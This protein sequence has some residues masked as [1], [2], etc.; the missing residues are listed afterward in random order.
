MGDMTMSYPIASN[1]EARLAALYELE[2]L[3][4]PDEPAFDRVTRLVTQLLNVPISTIT[5]IDAERQWIKSRVGVETRE[6][7][8]DV[9]FCAYTVTASE[10]LIVEDARRILDLRKTPM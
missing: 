10:P 2:L 5:L 6:T 9:A 8:R 3:D 7:G 1:E 4:T